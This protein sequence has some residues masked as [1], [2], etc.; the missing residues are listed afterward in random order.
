MIGYEDAPEKCGEINMFEIFGQDVNTGSAR[1]GYGIHPWKDPKLTDEFYQDWMDIDA[2]KFHVYALEWTPSHIDFYVDNRKIKRIQQS[3]DYPMQF[4]LSLYEL[5]GG[6]TNAPY[7]REF[8]VD[9][10][11]GYKPDGGYD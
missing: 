9:Y 11:R 7:P 10:L 8:V 2:A 6:D 4:M 3:P 5:P 1:V